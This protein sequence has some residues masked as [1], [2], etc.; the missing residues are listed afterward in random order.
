[1]SA[2]TGLHRNHIKHHILSFTD[3]DDFHIQYVTNG[4]LCSSCPC[5]SQPPSP[6]FQLAKL[7]GL[8]PV[9]REKHR[10][11]GKTQLK[12]V[13]HEQIGNF[14]PSL[15]LAR[16]AT[17]SSSSLTCCSSP[18]WWNW[19]QAADWGTVCGMGVL[20]WWTSCASL[21]WGGQRDAATWSHW[22]KV[23][24]D[25]KQASGGD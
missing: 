23:S 18:S 25:K 4:S 17:F 16:N 15:C 8:N 2:W 13:M 11:L 7:I 10:P 14:A 12:S 1:M 6:V 20:E 24:A 21:E 3:A 9:Q 22:Q 5:V 19:G